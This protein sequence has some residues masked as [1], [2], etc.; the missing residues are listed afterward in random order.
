[1]LVCV[2]TVR[3]IS[4][5]LLASNELVCSLLSY[6]RNQTPPFALAVHVALLQTCYGLA[7]VSSIGVLTLLPPEEAVTVTFEV[8]AGVPVAG[9]VP[10][11]WIGSGE[12]GHP[13]GWDG[14]ENQELN[15]HRKEWKPGLW[16][17]RNLE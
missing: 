6:A 17:N 9:G 5:I 10:L 16:L 7:T 15:S 8:P 14:R 1:M 2:R 13:S 12:T 3:N 11:L 4:A